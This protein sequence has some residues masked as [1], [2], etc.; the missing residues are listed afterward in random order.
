MVLTDYIG[1]LAA[2][3]GTIAWI[4]QVLKSWRTR[5]TKS[6]SLFTNLFILTTMILWLTYGIILGAWPLILAN[7]F[8]ILLLGSIIIAKLI[9]K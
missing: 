6:L 4:P 2:I 5:D 8:S 7:L 1:Y 3:L 9:F